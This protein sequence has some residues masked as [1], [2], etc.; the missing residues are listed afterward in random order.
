MD[1][2]QKY[3]AHNYKP[4]PVTLTRGKGLFL[5]DVEGK[6]YYDFHSGYSSTN[7]GHSHP[8]I[9]KAFLDQAKKLT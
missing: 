6:K 5:Y 3:V 8:K 2:E 9:L 1:K 4:L 7:Q